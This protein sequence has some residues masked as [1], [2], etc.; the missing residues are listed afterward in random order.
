M[1][2][3][4]VIL[5]ILLVV[6][7]AAYWYA[8]TI[9]ASPFDKTLVA[10]EPTEVAKNE[11]I[12]RL[13]D[14]VAC[15]ST[16]SG[17]PF[18]GGLAMGSPLGKIYSTN[19][20][21]DKETGIG[22]FSLA[23]FDN[24]VRRGVGADGRRLYPA[25]PYPSYAK[26][27]DA[28]IKALYR[29]FMDEVPAVKQVNQKTEI[30]W[31]LNIRWPIAYWNLLF[32]AKAQYENRSD[33]NEQWNRGAYLVQGAGHCGS[34]HTPRGLAF[35]E[36]AYDDRDANF[37]SGALLDGWYAPSLRN[38]DNTGLGRW[39]EGDIVAYLKQGR[40]AHG[41]VFGS[42][43]DA[44][45]NSTQFMTDNDLASIAHYLKSLPGDEKRDGAKWQYSEKI[46]GEP[47]AGHKIYRNKCSFCHGVDGKGRG[48]WLPPVTGTSAVLAA[49]N[50]SIINITLNG[51]PRLVADGLADSYR[52]PPFR[53]QLS[54]KDIADVLSYIRTSW[55]HDRAM[56]TAEDV[57]ALR[58]RTDPASANVHILQM[59]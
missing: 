34:C 44:F 8:A 31:P 35:Q 12:V 6:A 4:S 7:G 30:P 9:P 52:M 53:D 54:D 28:D 25:M 40:N 17:A 57:K 37:L 55:G 56:V 38:D 1:K 36:K 33:K 42:M 29:Y 14:C 26:L 45:N 22:N 10:A 49:Q 5:I 23:Q 58:A 43:T 51:S 41:V 3:L 20:T 50:A 16:E 27:T 39:S 24:A 32:A 15:H 18:S 19:I 13:A 48:E 47:D 46:V 21:P 2:K 11:Y 59:R